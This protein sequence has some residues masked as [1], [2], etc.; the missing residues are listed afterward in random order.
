ME[1]AFYITTNEI[2]SNYDREMVCYL[3]GGKDGSEMAD[4]PEHLA[5]RYTKCS[6]FARRVKQQGMILHA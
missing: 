3:C 1:K 6:H 4:I 5:V 2:C